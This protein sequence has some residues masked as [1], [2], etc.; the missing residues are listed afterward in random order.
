[1]RGVGC[2]VAVDESLTRL[3]GQVTERKTIG[4][5]RLHGSRIEDYAIIGDCETAALVGRDGSIDWLCWPRFSSGA[6]FAALLGDADNGRWQIAPADG[7]SKITRTYREHTLILET[8][9]EAKDGVFTLIDFMPERGRHSDIVRI[10]RGV[11]GQPAVRMELAIRFDYGRV[12]PWV[13]R[14]DGGLVAIAGPDLA[15][16]RTSVEHHGEDL[17]TI[18]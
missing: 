6:C 17:K 11:K 2:S 14:V 15:V 8:T 12:V 16:F 1:M 5:G 18:S 4:Q 3:R 9:F 13:E 10:V 7:K